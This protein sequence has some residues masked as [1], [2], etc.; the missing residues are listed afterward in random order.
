MMSSDVFL[1][2]GYATHTGQDA[3]RMSRNHEQVRINIVIG[4]TQGNYAALFTAAREYALPSRS[5]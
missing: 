2:S 3:K 4:I 5:Y 1:P